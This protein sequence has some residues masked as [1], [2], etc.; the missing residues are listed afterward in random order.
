MRSSI[1]LP[2]SDLVPFI[3]F[4]SE[5]GF[6]VNA[7]SVDW[8]RLIWRKAERQWS[9]AYDGLTASG[10]SR[11]WLRCFGP[12]AQSSINAFREMQ[13]E[14]FLPCRTKPLDEAI[15]EDFFPNKGE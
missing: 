11:T 10:E 3:V 9:Q 13:R 6:E 14:E 4:L 2:K 7:D 12:E 5:Q 15:I 1:K 8:R